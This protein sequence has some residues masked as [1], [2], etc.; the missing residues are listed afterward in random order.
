MGA[1][2]LLRGKLRFQERDTLEVFLVMCKK[3]EIIIESGS[4][5]FHNSIGGFVESLRLS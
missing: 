2:Y 4:G 5:V 3:D 1:I